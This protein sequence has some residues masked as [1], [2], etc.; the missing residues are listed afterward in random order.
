MSHDELAAALRQAVLAQDFG[1]T[2]DPLEGGRPLR[3]FPSLDLALCAFPHGT[4]PVFA[5]VLF[6]REHP[7]G[8]VA[9]IGADAGPVANVRFVADRRDAAGTSVL[10]QPGSDWAAIADWQPL[11]GSGVHRFVAP[12]P[13]SLLKLMVAVGV[14]L[15]VERGHFDWP[16]QTVEAMLVVSDNDATTTLIALLH[17]HGLLAPLHQHLAA[18]GL[19]GLRLDGTQP[20]GGWGNAA[21]AGVGRIQMTAWDTLRLLWLLDAD[22]PPPPWLPAGAV[23]LG[24][25]GRARLRGWLDAQAL[26]EILSSTLLAGVP[27]WV[28]GL[29]AQLPARWVG[30]DGSVE[31]RGLRFPPDVRP[32]NAAA[33]LRFAHK[34]GA[35]ENYAADAGIVR[36]LAPARP[37]CHYLVALLSSL[38]SRYAPGAPCATTW[39]LPALGAAIDR[40][41]ETFE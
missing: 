39:R 4:A 40:L 30:A 26:H 22:A 34:T 36:G 35:T 20:D 17:R 33:T 31:T 21:G 37:R 11:T 8:L 41:M 5:N 29:P 12:Y 15:G 19:H 25:P 6:S 13:A 27:G 23:L 10:W 28:P 2:P 14:A 16:A 38:G 7:Q 18:C 1:A 24:A 9:Q 3:H 32:A